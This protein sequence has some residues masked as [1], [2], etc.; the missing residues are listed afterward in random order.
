QL[1]SYYV[2]DALAG[3][4][5]PMCI[6]DHKSL[7]AL[8][9]VRNKA[10]NHM[11]NVCTIFHLILP[12]FEIQRCLPCMGMQEV[13]Y[14]EELDSLHKGWRPTQL[15]AMWLECFMCLLYTYDLYQVR[16][17]SSICERTDG[18]GRGAG[19]QSNGSGG[20][21]RKRFASKLPPWQ[22]ARTVMVFLLGLGLLAN[23]VAH[24]VFRVTWH[25]WSRV[26]LPFLF[27]SRRTYLKHFVGGMIRV[28]P[29]Q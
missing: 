11:L 14:T 1:A 23:M 7:V 2:K 25:R 4:E 10:W 19:G 29:R 5:S 9:L 26:T 15:G 6:L 21:T 12:M 20:K 24:Y 13:I 28:L 18:S 17:S 8:R 3:R 22:L 16:L 27:I